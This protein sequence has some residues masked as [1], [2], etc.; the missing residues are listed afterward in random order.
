MITICIT[1]NFLLIEL[2]TVLTQSDSGS[3]YAIFGIRLHFSFNILLV[4]NSFCLLKLFPLFLGRMPETI[5]LICFCF[6]SIKIG[7]QVN[8]FEMSLGV[9]R[10]RLFVP[11]IIT[12]FFTC[13]GILRSFIL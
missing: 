4:C 7:A 9:S 11:Q 8:G 1:F 12:I 3:R 10:L 5:I 13:C 6:N 2:L